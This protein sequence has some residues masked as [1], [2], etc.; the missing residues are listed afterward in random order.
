MLSFLMMFQ[1]DG[2]EVEFRNNTSGELVILV[3]MNMFKENDY[4]S[5]SI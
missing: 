3:N 1:K 2:S 5:T 4:E